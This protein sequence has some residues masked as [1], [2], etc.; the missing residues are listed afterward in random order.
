MDLYGI[1]HRVENSSNHLKIFRYLSLRLVR[2]A[3]SFQ[4][5]A[6]ILAWRLRVKLCP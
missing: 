6:A 3:T 4:A 1:Q 2:T 5:F